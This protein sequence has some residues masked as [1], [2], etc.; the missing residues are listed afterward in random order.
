MA[1]DD[2]NTSSATGD[3]DGDTYPKLTRPSATHYKTIHKQGRSD[4]R[5][6][7]KFVSGHVVCRLNI[8][9]N[10]WRAGGS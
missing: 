2:D 1:H 9:G 8:V 6:F 10:L 3:P 5:A 7:D 4:A